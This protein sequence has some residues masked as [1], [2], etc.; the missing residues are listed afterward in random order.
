MVDILGAEMGFIALNGVPPVSSQS[1]RSYPKVIADISRIR[2]NN[3]R[4]FPSPSSSSKE[5]ST[6]YY[7]VVL[8]KSQHCWI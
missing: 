4:N 3:G 8:V 5:P 1:P 2:G 6:S 7:I